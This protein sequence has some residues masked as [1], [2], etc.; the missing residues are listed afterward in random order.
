MIYKLI[1]NLYD[2]SQWVEEYNSFSFRGFYNFI[3]DFFESGSH[4]S[5]RHAETL[6]GWW[7][8]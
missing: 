4:G 8:K 7:I 3:V 6:L 1:F 5:K 2:A